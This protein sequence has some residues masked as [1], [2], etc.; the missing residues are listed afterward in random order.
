MVP[1]AAAQPDPPPGP[2]GVAVAP[3][4]LLS[5]LLPFVGDE[6]F[7][8]ELGLS[9]EQAKRLVAFRQK[10]WDEKYTTVRR[11]YDAAKQ[12][13]AADAEFKAVL[14]AAQRERAGQLAARVAFAGPVV[15]GT[16]EVSLDT[17]PRLA[18][19]R[20][21]ARH[22]ELV[23]ALK[24]DDAQKRFVGVTQ[25][26][27]AGPAGEP[28]AQL[29][30]TPD[31]TAAAKALLGRE[32]KAALRPEFDE[33]VPGGPGASRGTPGPV[34]HLVAPDV[35]KELGLTDEQ[36]KAVRALRSKLI[37]GRPNDPAVSPA[38]EKKARD[39][40]LA[41]ASAALKDLLTADQKARLGQI[42]R[43]YLA[44]RQP[45]W[46]F[47]P[48]GEAGKAIGVT[49][50][51]RKAYAAAAEARAAAVVEA[52]GAGEPLEKVRAAV[53]AA[54]Q[55]FEAAAGKIL[56]AD[57]QAKRKE[58]LGPPFTGGPSLGPSDPAT[59]PGFAPGPPVELPAVL[60]A[61]QAVRYWDAVKV[62]PGQAGALAAALNTFRLEATTPKR[63]R[64]PLAGAAE[65]AN[66][67]EAALTADQRRRLEQLD[68]QA[69]AADSLATALVGTVRA[70]SAVGK[71]LAVTD[72]QA[73]AIRAAR[74][75]FAEL[76]ALLDAAEPGPPAGKGVGEPRRKLRDALDAKILAVLTDGQKAKWQAMTG[77]PHPGFTKRPVEA[78][79][80]AR[81][82]GRRAVS[83]FLW[84]AA[85]PPA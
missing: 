9:P 57:Q 39:A 70:P 16:R 14:D 64:D 56:T 13:A 17:D 59:A 1:A 61:A 53:A 71:E 22:P 66:A 19:G 11:D 72:D 20:A 62:T 76:A 36:V 77:D 26:W 85:A 38:D 24:L 46:E 60:R 34:S 41:D 30:L 37:A 79:R 23:A 25:Y 51:Q 83:R 84:S 33:R 82:A 28:R 49:D 52:V 27:A 35:Q 7:G 58:W 47:R 68:L 75:E 78:G 43:Q 81:P 63:P 54:D 50:G 67:I 2:K 8:K 80:A 45:G 69:A 31:Q 15:R 44:G 74:A 5:L 12:N 29:Y 21:L 3:V 73:K 55:A 42:G 10:V 6:A 40:V 4:P 18:N 32:T 48:G 65:A